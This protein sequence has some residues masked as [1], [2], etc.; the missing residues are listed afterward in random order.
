MNSWTGLEQRW[1]DTLLAAMIPSARRE[2][3]VGTA[4]GELSA[5]GSHAAAPE[6]PGLAE[7]NLEPFWSELE[8]CAPPL[9]RLGLRV[10][11]WALTW[12]PLLLL[13]R[14]RTFGGLRRTDQDRLIDR[15]T[16]SRWALLRQL[17]LTLKVVACLAYFRDPAAREPFAPNDQPALT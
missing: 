2:P 11:V 15:A 7:L 10:A 8:R 14:A 3:V 13:G 17:A 1:R 9:L 4:N 12:A 6:L 16:R 5:R